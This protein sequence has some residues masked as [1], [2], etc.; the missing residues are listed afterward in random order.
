MA[1]TNCLTCSISNTA[2]SKVLVFLVSRFIFQGIESVG[3][4]SFPLLSKFPSFVIVTIPRVSFCG[5][6]IITEDVIL[7]AA[8]CL[9]DY[10]SSKWVK[11][12]NLQ[13]IKSDFTRVDWWRNSRILYCKRYI[14]HYN[15]DIYAK[16]PSPYDLALVKLREKSNLRRPWTGALKVCPDSATFNE[17]VFIGMGYSRSDEPGLGVNKK[18]KI[19][20]FPGRKISLLLLLH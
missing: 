3:P 4:V 17:G 12:R 19:I 13:M 5:G 18:T 8:H 1:T 15:F 11:P 9:F 6:T 7:T 2:F 14:H 16:S 20:I 10:K